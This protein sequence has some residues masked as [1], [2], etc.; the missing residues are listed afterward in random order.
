MKNDD[1][2]VLRTKKFRAKLEET[3]NYWIK[4]KKTVKILRVKN[5]EFSIT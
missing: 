5:P 3:S 1:F 4:F 2:A